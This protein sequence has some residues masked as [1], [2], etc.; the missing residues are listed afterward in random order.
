MIQSSEEFRNGR[1]RWEEDDVSALEC[2]LYYCAKL[3]NSTVS[4]GIL[5]EKILDKHTKRDLDSYRKPGETLER[6]RAF[7]KYF[8][9]TLDFRG[10][11]FNRTD[12]QLVIPR[13]SSFARVLLADEDIKLNIT[14]NTAASIPYIFRTLFSST[15]G[16]P[17][18]Y[19]VSG[20][21]QSPVI[22]SLGRSPNLTATFETVA[23]SMTKWMRDLSHKSEPHM[24]EAKE[25]VIHAGVRWTHLSLPVGVFLAGSLFCIIS[26][27]ET[28]RLGLPAWKGSG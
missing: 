3:Y 19:P 12:L 4:Q 1:Q 10:L 7:N 6:A 21:Q 22:L 24:G 28:R 15:D 11:D 23:G 14:Q 18:V 27:H 9:Y 20:A 26:I 2:A 13:N 17:L 25:W 8:N 5:N 16:P